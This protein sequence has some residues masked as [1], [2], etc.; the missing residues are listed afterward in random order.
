MGMVNLHLL[1]PFI[2]A[3]SLGALLGFERTFASRLDHEVED[4]LGGIRTYS[5]VSLFGSL[6]AFLADKYFPELLALSF[7][8]I[9]AVTLIL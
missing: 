5:L 9:I 7:A 8:G 1:Q 2:I 6:A 3:L 4:F